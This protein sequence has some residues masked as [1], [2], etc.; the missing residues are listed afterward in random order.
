MSQE[1]DWWA[2]QFV[3]GIKEIAKAYDRFCDT[4]EIEDFDTASLL[5]EEINE[6][7]EVSFD[8]LE[9]VEIGRAW[10]GKQTLPHTLE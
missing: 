8:L 9:F 5:H 6:A 1:D 2:H 3:E 4:R 7:Y 10:L